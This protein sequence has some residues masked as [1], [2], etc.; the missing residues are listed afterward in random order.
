M[1]KT[2]NIWNP[3]VCCCWYCVVFF[4]VQ[5][6]FKAISIDW[7][8]FAVKQ[9]DKQTAPVFFAAQ[10]ETETAALHQQ[11]F[12]L[13]TYVSYYQMDFIVKTISDCISQTQEGQRLKKGSLVWT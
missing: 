9:G 13:A 10:Q 11:A 2:Q 3:Q 4:S 12:Q 5:T 8:R 6:V 1:Q 7:L